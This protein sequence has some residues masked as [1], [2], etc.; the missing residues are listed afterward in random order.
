MTGRIFNIMKYAIHDG[1]GIRTT[2][3]FKGCPLRC[4]W[5][6][7]P[8][9][10]RF[11]QEL[12]YRPERC[13]GC[14]QCLEVCPQGSIS[15]SQG[16]V[17]YAR[18]QCSACG[19]CSLVCPAGARE[20]VARSRSVHDVM[21]EIEKDLIF[22]DES[23]GGVTFSGGEALSQPEFLGELLK[24]CR[25]KEIH[26]AVETCGYVQREVLAGLKDDVD[27][28]LFDLKHLDSGEHEKLTGVPNE[29]ILENLAWLAQQHP[30]VMVRL[31]VIPGHN[32]DEAHLDKLGEFVKSLR[33]IRE[34]HCLPYH[35]AG[36]EKYRRLGRSYALPDLNPPADQDME[37]IKKRL[38]G[39]GLQVSIGG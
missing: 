34:V 37:R 38:E 3:F 2:V 29:L 21:T 36:A 39:F 7:N 5:C 23:G 15:Y 24:E 28:F 35:K 12:L 13:V 22:Y 31:A 16:Q 17:S 30:R 19:Q 20:T 33:T 27:L 6:H 4:W 14:G 1:P 25:K 32:D 26:T 9:G 18:E 11:D 10:Q 8:E